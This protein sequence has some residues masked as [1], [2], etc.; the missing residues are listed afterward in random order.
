MN[1]KRGQARTADLQELT[2]LINE[3]IWSNDLWVIDPEVTCP[4][5]W[6]SRASQAGRASS[7]LVSH[8]S[9]YTWDSGGRQHL[10]PPPDLLAPLPSPLSC[11]CLLVIIHFTR[12]HFIRAFL[13]NLGLCHF[14]ESFNLPGAGSTP[15]A[16]PSRLP[17]TILPSAWRGEEDGLLWMWGD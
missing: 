8:Q 1:H 13:E 9:F 6:A 4:K 7:G 10:S 5:Q 2:C 12:Q 11:A 3:C 14:P 16:S 17:S 15:L